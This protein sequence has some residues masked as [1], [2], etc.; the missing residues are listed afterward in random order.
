M[1]QGESLV[2]ILVLLLALSAQAA[3]AQSTIFNVPTTDV[4]A[5]G[6]VYLEFD[7]LPQIPKAQDSGRLNIID[8]RIVVGPGGNVEVGANIPFNHI[9][10]TTNAFL[11]PNLK[12]KFAENAHQG[13]AAAA[14]GILYIPINHREGVGNYSLIYGSFSKKRMSAHHGPRFT[15]GPYGVVAQASSFAGPKAGALLGYEQ[16]VQDK[17][18]IVADWFSG[19]NSFGYFTP[20]ISIAL[21]GNG[22]LNAGYSIGNNS[23]ANDNAARNR[24]LF[25]YY[26]ITF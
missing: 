10:N 11:Q 1:K 18:S 12:W 3:M 15:F 2:V 24:L 19:K 6:K 21:P 16:P 20:G 26:G 5:K 13:L 7:Y 17:V 9:G 14:G 25:V 23:W 4:V 8:P 22:A